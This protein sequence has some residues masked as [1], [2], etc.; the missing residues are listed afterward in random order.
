MD[1]GNPRVKR[2]RPALPD[3]TEEA[4]CASHEPS[5]R[6]AEVREPPEC[7]KQETHRVRTTTSGPVF[8]DAIVISV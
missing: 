1:P 3:V 5:A 2:I 8:D 6:S 7:L 4:A